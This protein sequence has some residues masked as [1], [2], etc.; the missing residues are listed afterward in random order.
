MMHNNI[1]VLTLTNIIALPSSLSEDPDSEPLHS[2][3]HFSWPES[4]VVSVLNKQ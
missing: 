2:I 1:I 3:K 4:K